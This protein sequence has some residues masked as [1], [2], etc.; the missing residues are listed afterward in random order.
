MRGLRQ[1]LLGKNAHL[2]HAE[3]EQAMLKA[4]GLLGAEG[5]AA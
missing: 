1:Q 3:T 5:E 4:A 2:L